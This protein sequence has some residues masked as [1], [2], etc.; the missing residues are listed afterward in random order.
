MRPSGIRLCGF[1]S[2]AA[3]LLGIECVAAAPP[4]GQSAVVK[5]QQDLASEYDFIVVGGG[6]AGLTIADRLT[7]N[8]QC[9]YSTCTS[10]GVG[11]TLGTIFKTRCWWW[12][13]AIWTT[14]LLS[15]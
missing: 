9:E 13:M 15:L 8:S 12:N 6:T 11:L 10:A 4:R 3:L 1:L 7:E 2:A 14:T 5:R